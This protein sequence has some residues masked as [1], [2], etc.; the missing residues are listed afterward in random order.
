MDFLYEKMPEIL[1]DI[2]IFLWSGLWQS[3]LFGGVILVVLAIF[4]SRLKPGQRF[5]ICLLILVQLSLP[6]LPGNKFSLYGLVGSFF[7]SENVSTSPDPISSPPLSA[8]TE[9]PTFHPVNH[10]KN[11]T[12]FS[13]P[14]NITGP[15]ISTATIEPSPKNVWISVDL[16]FFAAVPVWLAGVLYLANTR[17]SRSGLSSSERPSGLGIRRLRMFCGRDSRTRTKKSVRKPAAS[18]KCCSNA[19]RRIDFGGCLAQQKTRH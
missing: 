8:A 18:T 19:T 7:Q 10:F 9:T 12:E 2:A 17:T 5:A 13:G 1:R 11:T 15:E 16:I 4:G 14:E 6:I 3:I